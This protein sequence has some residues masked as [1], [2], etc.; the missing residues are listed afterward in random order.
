MID[1]DAAVVF[2]VPATDSGSSG[3][4]GMVLEGPQG[5]GEFSPRSDAGLQRALVAASEGGTVGW[6]D[7]VR[8]RIPVARTVET[9]D[10][11]RAAAAVSGSGCRTVRVPVGARV[12]TADVDV[13][14]VCAARAAVG[15]GGQVR[16]VLEPGWAPG[17]AAA[18]LSVLA[19]AGAGLEFVEIATAEVDAISELRGNLD[20]PVAVW[21]S[22]PDVDGR[23]IAACADIVVLAVAALGGVRRALRIAEGCGLPAVVGSPGETSLGLAAGLALAGALPT[24]DFACA[25]GDLGALAGDLVDPARS[26]CPVDGYLPVAPMPPAP[27]GP[28][29][30]RFEVTD[31]ARVARWRDRL[32]RARTA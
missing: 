19:D 16:V 2:A 6:P 1:F 14:R 15:D 18:A 7:P 9:T 24:L 25:L 8:G 4:E 28:Q 21:A 5:W 10:A 11:H 13:A 20:V 22:G 27:E 3:V 23:Q 26:L 17:S 32:Q 31:R 29:L 12:E 30:A